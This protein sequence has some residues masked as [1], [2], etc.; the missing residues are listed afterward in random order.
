M[1]DKSS[2][3]SNIVFQM[4]YVF[5]YVRHFYFPTNVYVQN[6]S[7]I[8]LVIYW[9]FFACT[10]LLAFNSNSIEQD[11]SEKEKVKL[12]TSVSYLSKAQK[13]LAWSSWIMVLGFGIIGRWIYFVPLILSHIFYLLWTSGCNTKLK[14]Y[15]KAHN[16]PE[17][18]PA[19]KESNTSRYNIIKE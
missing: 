6:L 10:F 7:R 14:N 4:S 5:I 18:P 15:R 9:L 1:K 12:W 11:K 3:V 16:I 2:Y 13:A 8:L 19:R 17:P